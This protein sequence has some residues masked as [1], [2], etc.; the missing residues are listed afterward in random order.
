MSKVVIYVLDKIVWMLLI[1]A[2]T[3]QALQI[4]GVVDAPKGLGDISYKQD[5][6]YNF[7][8]QVGNS[9]VRGKRQTDQRSPLIDN[10][11]SK[12]FGQGEYFFRINRTNVITA[13]M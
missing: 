7:Q 4:A 12:Q 2:V 1:T 10:I 6:E 3:T 13:V 5:S 11:F 9:D 8:V